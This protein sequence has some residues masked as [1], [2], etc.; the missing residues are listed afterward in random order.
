[1][2]RVS[3]GY[4]RIHP[5]VF[6]YQNCVRSAR[7]AVGI[8]MPN[9]RNMGYLIKKHQSLWGVAQKQHSTLSRKL[10]SEVGV[11]SITGVRC[12]KWLESVIVK[13]LDTH[14]LQRTTGLSSDPIRSPSQSFGVKPSTLM[15]A[16]L[17]Q[18]GMVYLI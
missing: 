13:S 7:S 16:F 10:S 6:L 15:Q 18:I 17:V 14:I 5:A 2:S 4:A 9:I 3:F 1:M 11:R 12:T 8:L